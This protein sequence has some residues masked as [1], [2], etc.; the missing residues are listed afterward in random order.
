[1]ATGKSVSKKKHLLHI[2]RFAVAATA[3]YFAFR[4]KPAET[5]R[6]FF[7]VD[8]WVFTAAVI[9]YV[10]A[11]FIFVY[12]W[13]ILLWSQKIHIEFWAAIRL[14]FLGLF[15][16]NCLP[17]S[18]GGDV[19]RAW[20]VTKHTDKKVEA[21]LSV[22]VDRAIGLGSTVV[23]ALGAYWLIPSGQA[24]GQL[25]LS[26][27]E[28]N[29]GDKIAALWPLLAVAVG[30]FFA[31][32]CVVCVSQKGRRVLFQIRHKAS[33]AFAK[34]MGAFKLYLC[35]P[36]TF[37]LAV[38]LSLCCQSLAI[39]GFWLIGHNLGIEAQL[40][41]YFMFYPLSWII[42]VIPI[43][44]GGAGVMELGLKGMFGMVTTVTVDQG[45]TLGLAQ[46]VIFLVTSL[47][48]VAI[49]LAGRHLPGTEDL[50]AE[51]AE[52]SAGL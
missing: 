49:H 45:Q 13:R 47:P 37:V 44:V 4:E 35:S 27:D 32:L 28:L 43:S 39:I 10:V 36:L 48:G 16:N 7:S 41:Y 51:I 22:F 52:D 50:G 6:G 26:A 14:H 31:G 38:I 29:I 42:G 40:K 30:V 46:R 11:Q 33:A 25:K 21:A 3:L 17:G 15:Y 5:F 19:L 24:G 20:Y 9:L 18:V 34:S 2:L 1:M 12:R 23:M 8:I